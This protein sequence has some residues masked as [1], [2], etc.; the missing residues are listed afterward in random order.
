IFAYYMLPSRA[1][2]MLIGGVVYLHPVS[3]RDSKK[4]PVALAGLLLIVASLFVLDSTTV[5]P[6]QWALLPV[7]GTCLVIAAG[8]PG[9]RLAKH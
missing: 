9:S 8:Y 3:L 5:W 2:E 4:A 6:G 7:I 1:W